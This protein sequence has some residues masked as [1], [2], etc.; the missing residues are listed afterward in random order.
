MKMNM[1]TPS[2]WMYINLYAMKNNLKIMYFYFAYYG[3]SS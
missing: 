2:I 3:F 1:Y